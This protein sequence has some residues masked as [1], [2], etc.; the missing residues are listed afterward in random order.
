MSHPEHGFHTRA[1]HAGE[2]A[3]PATGAHG[4]PIYQNTTFA[5]GTMDR[6]D[7]F[8]AG[9]DGVFGYSRDHN[10]TV[11]HLEQKIANLEGA[12]G[13]VATSSGMAA[14]S[15]TLLTIAAGGH[16]VAASEI[17]NTAN[18]LVNE[19][20]PTHNIRFTRVDTTDLAA[21]EAACEADTRAI[22]TECFS[23]PNLIVA[24]L[25]A[26]ADIAHRHGALLIIDNTFLSPAILRP[27]ELGADLVIHSATK[28]LAGHGE[29]I[30]GVVS[31]NSE[32]IDSLRKKINRLGGT[33][34]AMSA[35]LIMTGIKTLPLRIERHSRNAMAVATFL[36]SHPMVESIRY[37]GLPDDSGHPTATRLL[38]SHGLYGGMMS[39]TLRDGANAIGPFAE[40]LQLVT[41][42]TSLG[43]TSSLAWPI[44][45]T[46]VVRLS[47][48]LEDLD[49]ILEDLDQAL[50]G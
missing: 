21:V 39:M 17:Y 49:D 27:I 40:A 35:W 15:S 4:T 34:S 44:H 6:F 11:W 26:L 19:D 29:V 41:F 45:N 18:K 43:D 22:Y 31:G 48:G 16:V 37:P 24:D 14:I 47:I 36:A 32:L 23:N 33:L 46:D 7:T 50:G 3:D 30:G 13:T 1:I 25:P 10:P 9:E 38:G 2:S 12:A 8:W 5:L 42:A 28:Y 20:L